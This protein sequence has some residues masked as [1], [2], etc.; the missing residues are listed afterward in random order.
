M[1]QGTIE[2]EQGTKAI[3][4]VGVQFT[5]IM[6]KV[7]GIGDSMKEINNSVQTV[8]DG[9]AKIV[10]AVDA[11]DEV[12]RQTADHMSMIAGTTQQQS[13]SNEEIA[14]ASHALAK[15]ATDMNDMIGEF[16]V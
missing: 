15:M 2:V 6:N 5:E 8:S 13:A 4:E 1:E 3:R 12:S 11:I 16:Q 7:N 14:A 10:K 9:A